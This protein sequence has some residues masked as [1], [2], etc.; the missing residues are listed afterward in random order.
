MVDDHP[1]GPQPPEK[2]QHYWGQ[3]SHLVDDHPLA[4]AAAFFVD[5]ALSSFDTTGSAGGGF[6]GCWA[7]AFLSPWLGGGG[8][9]FGGGLFGGAPSSCDPTSSPWTGGGDGG[10]ASDIQA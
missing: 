9:L 6:V 2:P 4:A 8:G 5:A 3:G 7:G 1:L 10:A